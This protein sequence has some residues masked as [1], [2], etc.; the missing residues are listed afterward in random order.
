MSEDGSLRKDAI[1]RIEEKLEE[2]VL[3]EVKDILE[4]HEVKLYEHIDERMAALYTDISTDLEGISL[5]IFLKPDGS[6]RIEELKG[7]LKA[8]VEDLAEKLDDLQGLHDDIQ[9]IKD[10]VQDLGLEA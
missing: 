2:Y 5:D 6:E 9:E 8:N 10:A 4:D 1:E 7:Q 3:E